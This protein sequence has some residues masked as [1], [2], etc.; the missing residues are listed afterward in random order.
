MSEY[1]AELSEE[2]LTNDLPAARAHYQF[3]SDHLCE[4]RENYQYFSKYLLARDI[5]AVAKM[6]AG[7]R[8]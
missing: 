1:H 3:M 6:K 5:L 8:E 2:E 7:V 4:N